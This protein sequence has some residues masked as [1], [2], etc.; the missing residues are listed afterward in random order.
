NR[1]FSLTDNIQTGNVIAGSLAAGHGLMSSGVTG[2]AAGLAN[3]FLR[4]HGNAIAAQALQR[5]KGLA[6]VERAALSV[7][8]KIGNAV[9][10]FLSREGAKAAGEAFGT[11]MR[12]HST[13]N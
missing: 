2:V 5:V 12:P 8:S 11:K 6:A 10:T 3:K 13:A 4:Q 7:T 1:A 9:S